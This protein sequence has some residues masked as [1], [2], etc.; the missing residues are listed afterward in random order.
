MA[1]F[2]Q[3]GLTGNVVE[4]QDEG[5]EFVMGCGSERFGTS[6]IKLRKTFCL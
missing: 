6:D 4:K 1:S 2:S 5:K 3:E